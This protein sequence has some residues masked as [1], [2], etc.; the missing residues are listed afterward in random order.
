MKNTDI[1]CGIVYNNVNC[2][3]GGISMRIGLC[4]TDFAYAQPADVLF[5]RMTEMGYEV[6]Q[7]AFCSVAE[8]AFGAAPHIEIP[9]HVSADALA[10][11]R[12]ASRET[13]LPIGAVNGTWNMTHSDREIR[14]EGL[15][16]F[17]GFLQ[18]VSELEC[19]IVTLC[20]GTR[21]ADHLWKY[22]PATGS[23]EAWEDMLDS[24]RRAAKLAEHYG[25]TM[26]IETEAANVID[27]PERAR[28]IM[29]EVGS[30]RLKMIL[31]CANLF[32]NGEACPENV[33]PT[34]DRAMQ[35]FGKDI[36]LA[37]GKDIR[38]GEGIDFCGTGFGIVDF[39]YMVQSLEKAGYPGDMM[40]HGIYDEN[41]LVPCLEFMKRCMGR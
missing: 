40:L 30:P 17:D 3:N 13:G 25:V 2:N 6:T 8:C 34:I 16:R 10:A 38:A 9:D 36:V 23:P 12:K 41:D 19:P 33:R 35:Y 28:R 37:H 22:D 1:F 4:T 24:M 15:R 26:A 31:D 39:P 14:E 27:T 21:S 20:S 5:R 29:D 32:H 11:I 18:A 7:L